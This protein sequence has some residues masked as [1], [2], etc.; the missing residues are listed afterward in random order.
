MEPN[1]HPRPTDVA[2]QTYYVGHAAADDVRGSGWFVGQ[3]VPSEM[4]MRH[5]T[6]VELKWGIHVRGDRRPGGMVSYGVATT[7]SI[8]IRGALKVMML[9]DGEPRTV[10]LDRVGDYIIFGPRLWHE[11]EA[12]ADSVVLSIRF[13]SVDAAALGARRSS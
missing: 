6:D 9:L 3:F 10:T 1:D 13:P 4:G 12:L 2:S 11:W 7:V 8:L 5:Q